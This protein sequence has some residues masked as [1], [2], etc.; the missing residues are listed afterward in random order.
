MK[1]NLAPKLFLLVSSVLVLQL[2]LI[3]LFGSTMAERL[4]MTDKQHE[5]LGIFRQARSK[6]AASGDIIGQAEFSDWAY[7][8]RNQ[9]T[10][11]TILTGAGYVDFTTSFAFMKY[12]TQSSLDWFGYTPQV[13]FETD[14]FTSR[15]EGR[16]YTYLTEPLRINLN[17]QTIPVSD[18]DRDQMYLIGV[19]EGEGDSSVFFLLETPLEPIQAAAGL[20]VRSSLIGGIAALCLGLLLTAI[21][22]YYISKPIRQMKRIAG[23]L[24]EMDFTETVNVRSRDEVGEL[25]ESINRMSDAM[26]L[27]IGELSAAND[28]LRR[29]IEERKRVEAAQKQLVSNVSHELKTPLALISGYAEGLRDGMA[30]D[31]ATRDEYCDVILDESRRMTG[32]LHQLL[33]LARLQSGM[34][35][36]DPE[37]VDLSELAEEMTSGFVLP[38]QLR[39]IRIIRAID[40]GITVMG[41]PSACEQTFRNYLSNAMSHVPDEGTIRVSLGPSDSGGRAR[42]E[43][44]NSGSHIPHEIIDRV[45]DSFFRADQG[46]NRDSGE[47]GLGLSIV[48]AHMT[49]LGTPFGVFNTEDGVVF[50][51]EFA[52]PDQ[53]GEQASAETPD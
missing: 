29:D 50:F 43:V 15:L 21:V 34:D 39:R 10:Y 18:S 37:P 23:S 26:Q 51:A 20:A 25:G 46:R 13:V 9:S 8:L 7:D 32:L 33:G 40:E 31:P 11:I 2:L 48:K 3:W 38:A 44:Y 42:L 41:D 5:L 47:V 52:L 14:F 12:S 36:L 17:N 1:L 16:E 27:Y 24:A 4:Y 45:W 30:E 28:Q 6:Y 53:P 35:R 19:A 49:R 22:A